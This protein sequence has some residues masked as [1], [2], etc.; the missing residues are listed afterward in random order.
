MFGENDESAGGARIRE[1]RKAA[2]L[3]QSELGERVGVRQ[4]VV[5]DWE[6]GGLESWRD[7]VEAIARATG[8]PILF[9]NH[10]EIFSEHSP[11]ARNIAVVGEV[12]GGAF[13]LALEY[14]PEDRVTVPVAPLPGYEG[15]QLRAL[16]VVGPS[17]NELYP[18]GT[19]VIVASAA[20]TDVRPGD[21]VV[22]YSR[23][24]ELR[25][26][27]IKELRVEPDGRIALWP[28]SSHPDHQAP[29]YLTDNDQ[30]GPEIAYVVVGSFRQEDRPPPPLK[31]GKRR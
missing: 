10:G 30:D 24:G 28:R 6:R 14:A 20:D 8:K 4:S 19:F 2:G 12:Q 29:I 13:R 15:V 9:F 17:V 26:A 27:T 11:P 23:Q 21:K 18:D 25:E 31:L 3:T 22:V 5:S 7:Y 16:R 1:A